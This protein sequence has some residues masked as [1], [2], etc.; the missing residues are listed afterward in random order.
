M[1][2]GWSPPARRYALEVRDDHLAVVDTLSGGLVVRTFAKNGR[3]SARAFLRE[4]N[5]ESPIRIH[6]PSKPTEGGT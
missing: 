6:D 1:P 5:G 4:M 2:P 3:L